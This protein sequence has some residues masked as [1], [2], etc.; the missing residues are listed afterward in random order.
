MWSVCKSDNSLD[1]T[2]KVTS[3]KPLYIKLVIEKQTNLLNRIPS[4]RNTTWS[5]WETY[6]ENI[7]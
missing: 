7:Y 2:I 1:D 5:L 6:Q 4:Q 3:Y